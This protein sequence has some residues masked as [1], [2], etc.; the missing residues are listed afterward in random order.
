[1]LGY[2]LS[3]KDVT[4]FIVIDVDGTQHKTFHMND[5]IPCFLAQRCLHHDNRLTGA[6]TPSGQRHTCQLQKAFDDGN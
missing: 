4:V 2:T 3:L 1:M 6:I 5:I